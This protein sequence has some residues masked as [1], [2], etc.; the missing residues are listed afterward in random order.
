M[1]Y[2]DHNGYIY[3]TVS[4]GVTP[5]AYIWTNGATIEDLTGLN[6]GS[7]QLTVTDM[8]NCHVTLSQ[9][10]SEPLAPLTTAIFGTNLLC[11]ND[12]TGTDSLAISGGTTPY[13]IYWNNGAT[14][15][16]LN[17]VASGNYSVTVTDAHGCTSIQSNTL[18]QPSEIIVQTAVLSNVSCYG[19]HDGAAYLSSITGGVTPFTIQW[20]GPNNFTS[21]DQTINNLYAGTYY[22]NVFD[23][24]NCPATIH[25]SVTVTQPDPLVVTYYKQNV[26][27]YGNSTGGIDI[28]VTGGTTPYIYAWSNSA[29]TQDITDLSAGSYTLTL[30]DYHGCIVDTTITIYQPDAPLMISTYS[31]HNVN[32]FGGNDGYI[33]I[34]VT[35]GT[36]LYSY[37]W[38]NGESTQT[39]TNLAAGVYSVTVT[40]AHGCKVYM[41][42]DGFDEVTQPDAPL[43]LDY[44]VTDVSCNG[45]SDG[46][47][48]LTIT[49]GTP[50]YIKDWYD[51]LHNVIGHNAY[52]DGIPAGN[53][54]V[55][56]TDANNCVISAQMTVNQPV[57][58]T[59]SDSTSHYHQFQVSCY[60]SSDGWIT[61]IPAGGTSPYTYLWDI[62]STVAHITGLA[63]G[64][65]H[66]TVTDAHG[67]ISNITVVLNGPTPVQIPEPVLVNI[68]CHGGNNGSINISPLGGTGVF[69]YYWTGPNNFTA[70]SQN[71]NNLYVGTYYITVTDQNGCNADANYSLSE[72]EAL[73]LSSVLSNYNGFNVNCYANND[74]YINT[75][76][77]GGTSGY[78]YHWSN[79]A[80]TGN[81]M[82]LYA[83]NYSLTVTDAH[84]CIITGAWTL[85]KPDLLIAQ[86]NITSNYHD[87]NISCNGAND[88]AACVVGQGGLTPYTYLWSNGATT[89]CISGLQPISYN[90]TIT[91]FNGCVSNSNVGG[92]LPWTYN[93]TEN[94]A[95]I[96]LQTNTVLL[97]GSPA[98]PIAVGDYIGVFY[99]NGG[100]LVCGGYMLWNGSNNSITAWGDDPITVGVKEG[101]APGETYTWKIWRPYFGEFNATAAYIPIIPP[102]PPF[103]ATSHYSNDGI[104]GLLSL[105]STETLN[106]THTVIQLHQPAALSLSFNTTNVLCSGGYSGSINLTVTGGTMPYTYLWSPGGATTQNINALQ[107]GM[108][109]V[110]VMD[111]NNCSVTGSVQITSP[112]PLSYEIITNDVSCYG[113]SDG[114]VQIIPSGGV[115]PYT[116]NWGGYNPVALA[117]GTYN[118]TITDHNNCQQVA[119]FDIYQPSVPM[120][121]QYQANNVTCYGYSN[122]SIS[123]SVE[124]GTIT[125]CGHY[126]FSWS[127]PNYYFNESQNIN[128]LIAG[129][130]TVTVTDCN[131]CIKIQSVTV[132]QPDAITIPGLISNYS[133]YGVSCNGSADGSINITVMGGTTPYIYM[134]DNLATTEDMSGLTSG[135]YSV[136]VHDVNNCMGSASFSLTEPAHITLSAVAT[137]SFVVNG[138]TYNTTC[139]GNN[140]TISLSVSGGSGIYFYHWSYGQTTQN[141]NGVPAGYYT[142]TVTD[143]NGCQAVSNTVNL[144]APGPLDVT[145]SSDNFNGYQ[146]QCNGM[147]ANL[148]LNWSGGASPYNIYFNNGVFAMN[149]TGNT[150]SHSGFAP[151]TYWAAIYDHNGCGRLSNQFT[152][153]QPAPIQFPP[154]AVTSVSCHGDGDGSINLTNMLG[155]VPPF[156]YQWDYNAN[157]STAAQIT[158][159]PGG[160]SYYVVVWD[161]NG[162]SEGTTFTIPEPAP[163]VYLSNTTGN[164]S[165]YEGSNGHITPSVSGGTLPYSYT[166]MNQSNVLFNQIIALPAGTYSVTVTDAHGCTAVMNGIVITQP[167]MLMASSSSTSILCHGGNST[168]TVSATGGTLPY[169]GTGT[170]TVV[171][172]TYSYTVSDALGCNSVTTITVTEPTVLTASSVATPILCNGGNATV[173]VTASGGTGLISGTGTFNRTA[174]TWSFTVTD[175]NGCTATTSVTIAQPTPVVVELSA[176]QIACYGGNSTVT[177]SATGGTGT[178]TGTGTFTRTFGTWSFTVTDAN[179]CSGSSSITI[180]QPTQL[181]AS[182]STTIVS[183]N[184]G[185]DG[186][187][188]LSVSGGITPYSFNWADGPTT[189]NRSDLTA[190][191]YYVVVYDGNGCFVDVNATITENTLLHAI[192]NPGVILCQGGSTNVVITATGGTVPYS[193]TGTF[194]QSVGSHTYTVTDINQCTANILVTLTEP[195]LLQ[196]IAT[197]GF[198][199]C[200]GGS[201]SVVITSTGGIGIVTGTGTFT[202]S[203]G[204]HT[205]TVTDAN[206]C[207]A[208]T[209]VTLTEPA[210][211][212]YTLTI[213]SPLCHG[214]SDGS[215]DLNVTGGTTPYTFIW[216]TGATDQNLTNIGVGSY[217]VTIYDMHSCSVSGSFVVTQPNALG[218]Q[219]SITSS[220][221]GLSDGEILIT[222]YSGGTAPYLVTWAHTVSHN[223]IQLYLAP[224][225]YYATITDANNCE[226]T[227]VFT[228]VNFNHLSFVTAPI[229]NVSCFEG[230]DGSITLSVSGG[231][232]PLTY[233]WSNGETTQNAVNLTAGFYTVTVID[234][235][236]C[237]GTT[238]ATVIQAPSLLHSSI[239]SSAVS[240]PGGSN[241]ALDLTVLG[242]LTPYT[243]HWNTGAT[244]EDLSNL[245]A[246]NYSVT[247]TDYY[248]CQ[249][250]P[251]ATVEQPPVIQA[252]FVKSNY[253]G[254]NISCFGSA[255]GSIDM[256]VIGGTTPYTYLWSTG[257]TTQNLANTSNGNA[258]NVTYT[259][260]ITD[261]HG[262]TQTASTIMTQPGTPNLQ[263]THPPIT[264]CY[265][266]PIGHITLTVTFTGLTPP[267]PY[268][269]LWSNG[270]TTQSLTN[271]PGGIYFVTFTDANGCQTMTQTTLIQPTQVI[272]T[273]TTTTNFN[274]YNVSCFGSS[275]GAAIV[276]ATG[277]NGPYTFKWSDPSGT[278]NQTISGI[279]AG[280]FNVTVTDSHTC[281]ATSSV[282]LTQP[283][284]IT[285][286]SQIT[287][288]NCNGNNT[289]AIDVTPGGGVLPYLFQWSNSSTTQ[290]ISNLVAGFY[291]ITL[292]DANTCTASASYLVTQ[293]SA[294]NI[295]NP[296]ITKV[297]CYGSATGMISITVF[298]GSSPYDFNWSNGS[299]VQNPSGL[300]AG[301]Y[302]LT[303][304]DAHGCTKTASYTV[305]TNPQLT[306][307]GPINNVSCFGGNNGAI[308]IIAGGGVTPYL[309]I[310]SDG[311]TSQN[312]SVLVAGTYNITVIDA[313]LCS[314]TGSFIVTQPDQLIADDVITDVSCYEGTN[315]AI[316]LTVTGGTTPYSYVW[317][318]GAHTKDISNLVAG[319]YSVVITDTHSCTIS[320]AYVVNQPPIFLA[321]T[322]LVS[323]ISCF[324]SS[325]GVVTVVETNGVAPF[326]YLWSNGGSTATISG[327]AT[328]TYSVTVTDAH[329]CVANSVLPPF[330]WNFTVTST[331]HTIAIQPSTV[332]DIGGSNIQIGDYIGVFYNYGG[333]LH[334]GGYVQWTAASAS[335]GTSLAAWGVDVSGDGFV[336]GEPFNWKIWRSSFGYDVNATAVANPLFDPFNF[337]NGSLSA[338]QS[339][340]V[341]PSDIPTDPNQITLTQPTP[342]TAAIYMISSPITCAGGVTSLIAAPAGGTAPYSFLWSNNV[343]TQT[344][345]N[346]PVGTYY[347]T[348]TDAHGCTG[349]AQYIVTGPD[350]FAFSYSVNEP[351]CYGYSNG[352]ADV[353]VTGGASP[354]TIIW[355]TIGQFGTHASNLSAITYPLFIIDSHNCTGYSS[356]SVAQPDAISLFTT[357]TN[358][359]CNGSATGAITLAV[360]G[361]TSP[362]TYNWSN[363][364]TTKDISGL[365]AGTYT[366]IVTDLNGCTSSTSA[367]VTQSAAIG[368][369]YVVTDNNCNY[370]QIGAINITVTGG[371][372]PYTYSWSNGA[373]T[374][375]ISGLTSGTYHVVVTDV[376]GCT[377]S[378]SATVSIIN[379]L[380]ETLKIIT[381][382]S[383]AEGNNGSVHIVINFGHN[384][385]TWKDFNNVTLT[386]SYDAASSTL[387]NVISGIYYVNVYNLIT[388]CTLLDTVEVTEPDPLT[389]DAVVTNVSCYKGSNGGVD[390]TVYG[391][392]TPYTY[393][394]STGAVNLGTT[395]DLT[396]KKAGTYKVI[397]TDA[398]GCTFD[399]IFTLTQPTKITPSVLISN[400]NCNGDQSGSID[401]SVSGGI[402]PYLYNWSTGAHTQDISGLSGGTYVV[403]VTDENGCVVVNTSVVTEPAVLAVTMS[404]VNV[405]C[406]GGNDGH[407]T[408]LVSGGTTPPIN[409][410]WSNGGSNDNISGI[411]AGTYYV[412][413]YDANGC[414]AL[415][416][417]VITEPPQLTL[418]VIQDVFNSGSFCE[419]LATAGGGSPSYT[420]QWSNAPYF[421]TTPRATHLTPGTVYTVTVTDTH[422]CSIVGSVLIQANPLQPQI[423]D[424]EYNRQ[425]NQQQV[426]LTPVI[427]ISK[428]IT[429]YPNPNKEGR[430]TVNFGTV[431]VNNARIKVFDQFGK[432][433]YTELLL[434]NENS[435][436]ILNLNSVAAGTYFLQIN[437]DHNGI[438]NKQLIITE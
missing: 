108:Y 286:S 109:Y 372:S 337:N 278:T 116:F 137:S 385:I 147:T 125:P 378:T 346:I 97:I 32:C 302:N 169:T 391:G 228:V 361:G 400:L 202:Q 119:T 303:I 191:T 404:G 60:G 389:Y 229:H 227:Q 23:G 410:V 167:V 226:L 235:N 104:S 170:Y 326:T 421:S 265:G 259:V 327:L 225:N 296:V 31:V 375:D 343:T 187:I 320:G 222:G 124:G 427:D 417:I 413:V 315:G 158:G 264:T 330:P 24:N 214:S 112:E 200:H 255:T 438:L 331:N 359:N 199:P 209:I 126:S 44:E 301:P 18:T 5:Y 218:I 81:I 309:Y 426:N 188:T 356:V 106:I 107:A 51:H 70:Y 279:T 143:S 117:A 340:T 412:S 376:N 393:Q 19:L 115:S 120:T 58:L 73:Q 164:V 190:G 291:S 276:N 423:V 179:G 244:T 429:V 175:A 41:T 82:N 234:A 383:C 181:T 96:L 6:G 28:T 26:D 377:G 363:G 332:F 240:C 435:L 79:G 406:Y 174:G 275:N 266:D 418:S 155:G 339:L 163:L 230:N 48:S 204:S 128:N 231:F 399:A 212:A 369:T 398:H 249:N 405:N 364:A 20:T 260:T 317:S 131:G 39:T 185:S 221:C 380:F 210:T 300:L 402:T 94:S 312:R 428:E 98:Q 295:T 154:N 432:L 310:W 17:H 362:Y 135:V 105:I 416:S 7:Y 258:S 74:G 216:N 3:V 370:N 83:G 207:T 42:F 183:C 150:Y 430:F 195:A 422:G 88:G 322:Q 13:Y 293:S 134:W 298:G 36:T 152:V 78:T 198:I 287:I 14:I 254:Y 321:N 292:T 324:G 284:A 401:L 349:T 101:F 50:P 166:A 130:Y 289:G 374:E 365:V 217:S 341:S 114:R 242:G 53:Y 392:T 368:I 71:I 307:S 420:Y 11:Y 65:Y 122:G 177:V 348:V 407:A 85:T 132:G 414:N 76:I 133:G 203:V 350:P 285:L 314:I 142:V 237:T 388:G 283:P 373:T 4:G 69:T 299:T 419:A 246:G 333:T 379:P 129:I 396:N 66:V 139:N 180:S 248:G 262:C 263:F 159:L 250:I 30:T 123:L 54:S 165:C 316:N 274:G 271:I 47:V 268:T 34:T 27:C 280:T 319:N 141:L 45:F 338:L 409:F 1:C 194:T 110:T 100:N 323:G 103:S 205:Y 304:T 215:I 247:V 173:T 220:T 395:Q 38:S 182:A 344:L 99:T 208:S 2:G 437:T 281:T 256:T 403:S 269:Y 196:A 162:C 29:T 223:P 277:G 251:T 168:V 288:V 353:T 172:G 33:N 366:V 40:D 358:I 178:Y 80:T 425:D 161:A 184:G 336:S 334:C 22:V 239:S 342:V 61:V 67:C 127:G 272:A 148:Y 63:A 352:S 411:Y 151:G 21:S 384:N 431:N 121:L 95:V 282:I 9:T 354:Y 10:I 297:N 25:P 16:K 186:T 12:F 72:P 192:A 267:P 313:A 290:D 111:V 176:T 241:G 144:T 52:I 201:T 252:T 261:H 93:V 64:S 43:A 394:W 197:P 219:Y 434:N 102:N 360:T 57:L 146:I 238:S 257:A 367:T 145:L 273:A 386:T 75:T 224:G 329:G 433:I 335:F 157:W 243:Y 253:N 35:G 325:D 318:N 328:G 140:G 153:T 62:G 345:N 211:L 193:G 397:V 371:T 424:N 305:T 87:Q 270:A 46:N 387:S 55:V 171:A 37:Q 390:L 49:G 355:T 113:G 236:G 245:P 160:S 59:L 149:V 351:S 68:S 381:P 213:N 189:Q 415:N 15:Q 77:S 138:N 118:V 136:I 294:I 382:V 86:A 308:N 408:A 84:G 347:L 90:V 436:F 306:L 89:S 92:N 311:P 232:L 8:N 206:G 357:V 156:T 56:V 233:L 91:D